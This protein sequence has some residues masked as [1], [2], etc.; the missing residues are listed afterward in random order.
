MK[1]LVKLL[2]Y[3]FQIKKMVMYLI[4]VAIA[5][6]YLQERAEARETD[7]PYYPQE[8]WLAEYINQMPWEYY[9]SY[10]VPDLGWFWIDETKDGVKNIIR[11]GKRWEEYVIAQLIKYIKPGDSVIDLGAHIGTISL[12][13]S[14][15]VGRTGKV[16][17]FEAERQIF[18]ELWHN[19]YSNDRKN[20]FPHLCWIGDRVEDV[21]WDSTTGPYNSNYSRV[22][23]E[24]EK[25][26]WPLSIR[27]LDS[28]NFENI[29]LMKIDVECSED[30]VLRGAQKL[31]KNS[32]P[33]LLI[34][35]M[36]G[37][38]HSS[39]PEVLARIANTIDT[40]K[41]MDYQ[42]TKILIDDYLAVPT[43]KL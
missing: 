11:Q 40:L 7:F 35:I 8:E 27:T 24:N 21:L 19:I 9:N 1:A 29:A 32:R 15:L 16:F 26:P 34:E 2:G 25:Q 5:V 28:F 3:K 37:F 38:G 23:K 10:Y 36:G 43:E 13:M 30:A 12:L 17:S 14:N 18:R 31:I 39:D 6:F 22:F 33:V 41:K 42:V 4:L 20:I